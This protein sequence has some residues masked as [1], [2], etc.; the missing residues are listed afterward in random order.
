VILRAV[1]S[2]SRLIWISVA[3]DALGRDRSYLHDMWAIRA[4]RISRSD[5][6]DIALAAAFATV[7]ELDVWVRGT[8]P[9][10][11]WENAL[12]LPLVALPLASRR[13]WPSEALAVIAVAIAAQALLVAGHPPSGLLYA[14][15]I[16][17]GAYS[18][19]AHAAWSGRSFAALAALAVAY[20]GIYLNAQGG[21]GGSFNS[22]VGVLVWLLLPTGAWLGGW[23]MR[24]RRRQAAVVAE[25]V[26][27][28]RERE[29]QRL[30]ALE[31]ERGRM[32]R[33]LHDIL[34]H[35]VSLMGVQAGAAEQVLTSDPERARPVLRSIQQISRDSVA[36]LRRLLGMLRAE[37]LEPDRAPQPSL[38]QLNAL[39]MRM[40]EAGLPVELQIEGTRHPLPA[41]VELTAYRVVQESLTN[42]LKHACPSRVEVVIRYEPVQLDVL[43]R[44]DGLSASGNGN[45]SGHG[46]LGMNERVSLYGGRLSAGVTAEGTYRVHAEIPLETAPS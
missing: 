5:L 19:G 34:A 12:L 30:V 37:E 42:A 29:Q 43:V 6:G 18:V 7:A 10:L 31:Q 44:N 16:L 38:D 15:P 28:E 21:L 32:A 24:R 8:V 17:L 46:L 1:W 40:S 26:R 36:E 41:G 20:D 45:G 23:Q 14:G 3:D 35:S 39:V 27:L 2:A 13:R 11:R 25:T 4:R 9:G 22:V 33:E